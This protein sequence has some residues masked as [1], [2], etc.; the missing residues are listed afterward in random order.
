M[1]FRKKS[2]CAIHSLNLKASLEIQPQSVSLMGRKDR[3]LSRLIE[4]P[5]MADLFT[6][7]DTNKKPL[8]VGVGDLRWYSIESH[9]NRY[10]QAGIRGNVD[11]AP[12]CV[13]AFLCRLP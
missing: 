4:R 1:L 7:N 9:F 13:P 5:K 10:R 11:F 3:F 12:D 8:P 6:K 2:S